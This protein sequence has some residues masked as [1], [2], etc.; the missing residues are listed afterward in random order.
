[1]LFIFNVYVF[2][3]NY[4]E[5]SVLINF[6]PNTAPL[7]RF[8]VTKEALISP[9]Y[10][11][12]KSPNFR[13]P[14]AHLTLQKDTMSQDEYLELY[15]N[16]KLILRVN[17]IENAIHTISIHDA[18]GN[19]QTRPINT[20]ALNAYIRNRE[21][22]FIE[23]Q[24]LVDTSFEGD[25]FVQVHYLHEPRPEYFS[26][27]TNHEDEG[28]PVIIG[29][30]IVVAKNVLIPQKKKALFP[31]YFQT[32]QDWQLSLHDQDREIRLVSG[33]SI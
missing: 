3:T 32:K 10:D 22:K 1:M 6:L 16:G 23:T 27:S 12:S 5:R 30:K 14:T 17:F 11:I 15:E 26:N 33:I 18:D 29:T 19:S 4:E 28:E 2:E 20:H 21:G 31:C 8:N 25:L 13:I 9:G 24:N 7:A